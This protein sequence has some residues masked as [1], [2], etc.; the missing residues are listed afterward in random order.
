MSTFEQQKKIGNLIA[1][2]VTPSMT[3]LDILSSIKMI[4]NITES[5]N[6]DTPL[7]KI[8]GEELKYLNAAMK[9]LVDNPALNQKFGTG[10]EASMQVAALLKNRNSERIYQRVL[11]DALESNDRLKLAEGV[12]R[13][14][15]GGAWTTS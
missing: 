5:V 10:F 8:A 12:K 6:N 11:D 7:G 3:S 9:A 2:D 1:N 15:T 14:N 4:N 13:V